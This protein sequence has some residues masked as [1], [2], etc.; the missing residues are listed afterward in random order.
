MDE[1]IVGWMDAR[2]SDERMDGWVDESQMNGWI[3]GQREVEMK[4]EGM[5]V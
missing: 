2:W 3:D 4:R 1:W 5:C